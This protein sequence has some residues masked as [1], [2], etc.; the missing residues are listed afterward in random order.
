M[1]KWIARAGSPS[2]ASLRRE[3]EMEGEEL[4]LMA[5]KGHLEILTEAQY[6]ARK[7]QATREY[8]RGPGSSRNGWFEMSW[9]A[10]RLVR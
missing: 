6:Q 5:S 2:T 3:L 7:S 10:A 1:S 4:H 8:R 9:C